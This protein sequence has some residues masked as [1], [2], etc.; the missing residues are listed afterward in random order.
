MS[1]TRLESLIAKLVK[2]RQ[3]TREFFENLTPEQWQLPVYCEPDWS[4]YNLLA[5]FVSAEENLL[6][7]SQDAASNGSGAPDGFDINNFNAHEQ[8]RLQG[9]S[10]PSLLEALD[11]ARQQTIDWASTLTDEQL[12]KMGRHPALGEISVEAMLT[13]IFGHQILHMR[14]LARMQRAKAV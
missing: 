14:D 4:A 6:Q 13:A 9:E 10:I 5:H 11:C 1:Q 2:G 3:R 7:L 12:D 8:N